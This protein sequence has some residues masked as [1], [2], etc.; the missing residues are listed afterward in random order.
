MLKICGIAL[1]LLFG[2]IRLSFEQALTETHRA[3]YFNNAKLNIDLRQQL[4]QM[5]LLAALSGFRAAV[6]DV[7]WIEANSA[8]QRTEWGRLK[9]LLDTVTSLQPRA[10]LFWD[11]A[12]WHMAYNA[13]YAA[14]EN[15]AQPRQA[16]RIKAQREYFRL[17]EDFLLR[18][19]Q[20]NPE[21]PLLYDRLGMLYRDKFGDHA[22]AA[23]AY[24]QCAALPK[25]PQYAARFAA[26]ELSQVPGHEQDA[27]DQL[28]AFYRKGKQEH[29]PT[30][31]RRLR[32]LEEKLK[33]PAE[34]R[35]QSPVT[36]P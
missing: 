31:I 1:L 14:F 4:G 24:K 25:A 22:R 29:L 27:Y 12:S 15:K 32:E 21:R 16:L 26:Y 17:G 36:P 8:W 3:A 30:L 2:G 20:N 34:Q 18:G 19:I 6:A 28:I 11:T 9:L 35:I 7:L 10:L 13:S 5:G 23:Q 33:L